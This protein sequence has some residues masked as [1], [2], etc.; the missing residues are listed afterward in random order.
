MQIK[1][2]EIVM[3]PIGDIRPNLKNNNVHTVEQKE[4]AKKIFDSTGFRVPLTIS[5]RTGL[6]VAGHL[7]LEVAKELGAKELPCMFQ[8]FADEAQEYAHLTADN[9][10]ASWA[11]LDMGK[12]NAEIINFPN[13]DLEMLALKDFVIELEKFEM[14][15]ELKEDMNKKFILEITFPNDMEMMDIHDD[16]TSRGYIVKIK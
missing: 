2:N 3:V 15:D 8:D 7:R 9:A 10:L 4:R 11:T 1:T 16:L 5:N 13:I 14:E 12:V 6:L